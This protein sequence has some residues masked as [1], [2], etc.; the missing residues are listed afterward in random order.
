M[1]IMGRVEKWHLLP[2][3]CRYFNKTFI[4][5]FTEKSSISRVCFRS[6]LELHP[7]DKFLRLHLCRP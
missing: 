7:L 5:M 4:E 1:L 6:F 2:S 3:H